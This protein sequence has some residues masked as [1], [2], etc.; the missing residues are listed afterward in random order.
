MKKKF[1]PPLPK[2][3]F[4]YVQLQS[5]NCRKERDTEEWKKWAGVK[6]KTAVRAAVGHGA[7]GGGGL[8]RE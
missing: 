5:Y 4:I 3:Y 2:V 7:G 6:G 1:D 8:R